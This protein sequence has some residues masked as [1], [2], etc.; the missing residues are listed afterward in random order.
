MSHQWQWWVHAHAY[1]QPRTPVESG[2]VIRM[3]RVSGPGD[4]DRVERRQA[5]AFLHA[6]DDAA[7]RPS[8]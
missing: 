5:T 6:N 4:V 7:N 3:L 8:W 1:D 2:Q